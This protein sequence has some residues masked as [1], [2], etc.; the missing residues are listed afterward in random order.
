MSSLRQIRSAATVAGLV[1]LAARDNR[2]ALEWFDRALNALNPANL[3]ALSN[4]GLALHELGRTG[5]ALAA[6]D[7]AIRAGCVKP[8]LFYNRGNLLCGAGRL[9]DA[10]ASYDMALRLDPAYPEA[11]RAGGPRFEQPWPL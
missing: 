1:C 4:R 6:Y 9:T 11:L 3:E 10:I 2:L 8:V 5:D 7:E